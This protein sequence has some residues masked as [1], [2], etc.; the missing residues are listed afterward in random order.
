MLVSMGAWAV[1]G[2]GH[3]AWLVRGHSSGSLP[4]SLECVAALLDERHK[5]RWSI[6]SRTWQHRVSSACRLRGSRSGGRQPSLRCRAWQGWITK[7]LPKTRRPLVFSRARSASSRV[8]YSTKQYPLRDRGVSA[9]PS[10]AADCRWLRSPRAASR[11]KQTIS[12]CTST[13]VGRAWGR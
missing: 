5:G 3:W 2:R 13:L 8:S 11:G 7:G 10:A 9:S 6:K 4:A 1:Y 12:M